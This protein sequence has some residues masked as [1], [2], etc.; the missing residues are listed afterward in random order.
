MVLS[1]SMTPHELWTWDRCNEK[2]QGL[3]GSHGFPDERRIKFLGLVVD[4]ENGSIFN[5]LNEIK[6]NIDE[7]SGRFLTNTVFYILSAYS[8]SDSS[9]PNGKLITSKQFRG[10][11]FTERDN[12]GERFRIIK[13]FGEEPEQLLRVVER[14]GGTQIDFPYG[15]ITIRV[16]ALPQI[17]ITLALTG[18]DEEF[19]ADVRIFYDESLR[20]IL[21]PEQT[22][23]LTHL[24]ISR[25]IESKTIMNRL[26]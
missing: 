9:Q 5:E 16:N 19:A 20:E 26:V 14:I 12:T 22:Y 21:D 7:R 13:E 3:R 25:I 24:T 6:I 18:V 17:P 8:D 11:G 2:I 15:D 10:V 1:M 4:T 23:F